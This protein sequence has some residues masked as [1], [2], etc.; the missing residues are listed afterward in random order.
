MG[1]SLGPNRREPKRHG[2]KGGRLE[3]GISKK[4][5]RKIPPPLA[6]VVIP[7]MLLVSKPREGTFRYR[8]RTWRLLFLIHCK[9]GFLQIVGENSITRKRTI[10]RSLNSP[11]PTCAQLIP[12]LGH[13]WKWGT[14]LP[15]LSSCF[16]IRPFCP[17]P[18]KR[19]FLLLPACYVLYVRICMY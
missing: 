13:L 16:V 12:L 19:G 2:Q 14:Y 8:E 10:V 15:G 9:T 3:T 1:S 11:V 6:Y 17:G 18:F 7:Y 5:L 4:V